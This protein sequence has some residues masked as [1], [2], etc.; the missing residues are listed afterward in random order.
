MKKAAVVSGICLG[1]ILAGWIPLSCGS[2]P[3]GGGDDAEPAAAGA[4]KPEVDMGLSE[5]GTDTEPARGGWLL[6]R[7]SAEMPHLNPIT[8]T[9]AYS[10]EVNG[11]LFDRLLDRD[12]ETLE[13]LPAVAERWEVSEDHLTYTFYLRKDMK[14]SDGEPLTAADVKFTYDK[15][16]DPATDAPHLKNYFKDVTAC[17]AVDDYTVRYTCSR[18]YYRHAVMLGLMDIIPE[19]VYGE[20]DFN[21]HP[22]NRKPVGSGM[23]TLS[24]W[25][26]GRFLVLDRNPEYETGDGSGIPYADRIRYEIITDDNAAFQKLSRGD[27]DAMAVRAEDWVRRANTEKFNSRF[28]KFTYNRP[29]YNYL[30]WNLRRPQFADK[31]VRQALTML[32]NRELIRDEIYY[33]LAKVISGNFMPGTPEHNDAIKPWPFDPEKAKALLSEAGWTDTNA[34]G[35]L[36]KDGTAFRFEAFTTNA[37]PVA[38]R[39][40]TI[41]KEELARAG[42]ELNIRQMEWASLLERVN[43]R[44]FDSVLMGWSMPPDPDPYQVWH[45]S[46][47]EAGSNYIGFDNAEADEIIEKARE[48]FDR[49]ERSRLYHRFHEIV[50][51]EQPYTFLLAPKSLL[52]VDKRV[53]GIRVYPFGVQEKEWFIPVDLRRYGK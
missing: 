29:A 45:S 23:Y 6:L 36:D 15:L 13:L 52:A 2:R 46:Q 33:G 32:M 38:E 12:P 27:I 43:N 28:N 7:L 41:Y 21:T 22:N 50:H 34:D 26:T 10:T 35:L 1:L 25:E 14:F 49:Q 24:E 44:D 8:S 48:S 42:I 11:W 39:I 9:D 19:H 17:E 20:G 31:R 30:G 53:H 5:F 37:N 16:M 4:E 3:A 51:E 47:A 18:P 40:F